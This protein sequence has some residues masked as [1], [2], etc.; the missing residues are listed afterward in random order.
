MPFS[1]PSG[2][3]PAHPTTNLLLQVLFSQV[4]S[5]RCDQGIQLGKERNGPHEVAADNSEDQG[6]APEASN[7]RQQQER[8]TG[9]R[10]LTLG[11]RPWEIRTRRQRTGRR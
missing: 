9:I 6:G 4:A 11:S 5:S 8:K 10:R 2:H 1:R 7:E 3:H